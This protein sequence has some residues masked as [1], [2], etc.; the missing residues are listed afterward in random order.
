MSRY[1]YIPSYIKQLVVGDRV[2]IKKNWHRSSE[3]VIFDQTITK[4]TETQITAGGKRFNKSNQKEHG[5]STSYST[6]HFLPWSQERENEI[7][8]EIAEH[9]RA[10]ERLN[11]ERLDEADARRVEAGIQCDV[12]LYKSRIDWAVKSLNQTLLR[13]VKFEETL[14]SLKDEDITLENSGRIA[15]RFSEVSESIESANQT[16]ELQSYLVDQLREATTAWYEGRTVTCNGVVATSS[17]EVVSGV[18]QAAVDHFARRALQ[19]YGSNVKADKYRSIISDIQTYGDIRCF[20]S[21]VEIQ[22]FE[23]TPAA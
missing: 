5:S 20:N 2:I 10:E 18:Y 7:R 8:A 3:D 12:E 16:L 1:I 19:R 15:E 22:A 17:E 11:Q 9:I 6:W 14:A 23:E 13:L 21:R 4:V